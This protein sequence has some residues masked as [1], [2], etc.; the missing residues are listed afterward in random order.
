MRMNPKV[1][2]G[3][4]LVFVIASSATVWAGLTPEEIAKLGTELTP[5]GAIKAGN[6]DGTI[7][8]WEG[9]ITEPPAGWEPGTHY[10]DP[11]ADDEVLFT[12]TAANVDDHADKLSVGQRALF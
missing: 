5:L 7:P 10:V 12:I 6:A 2:L 3:L 9:G 11:F 1:T 4:T 8:A